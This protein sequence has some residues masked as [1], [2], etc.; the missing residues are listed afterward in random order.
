MFRNYLKTRYRLNQNLNFGIN[1]N[2]MVEKAG[3]FFIW[4]DADTGALKPIDNYVVDD[5]Y[6]IIS[7]DPHAEWKKG[8]SLHSFKGRIY[9]IKR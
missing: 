3:R 5:F 7:F 9:Q 2:A 1:L 4:Q 6:R 8:R